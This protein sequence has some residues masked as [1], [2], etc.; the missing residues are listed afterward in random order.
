MLKYGIPSAEIVILCFYEGQWKRYQRV[1]E[2]M[3]TNQDLEQY[4]IYKIQLVKT[5]GLQGL[6]GKHVIL[7]IPNTEGIG[8]LAE[9]R[10]LNTAISRAECSLT[11]VCN[12]P[13]FCWKCNCFFECSYWCE[14]QADKRRWLENVYRKCSAEGLTESIK[15]PV[16]SDFVDDNI[17]KW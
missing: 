8:F 14:D 17:L 1:I 16:K 15:G 13:R 7:E 2:K 10:R 3:Q 9:G 11:I 5:D 12:W 4:D 6:Q